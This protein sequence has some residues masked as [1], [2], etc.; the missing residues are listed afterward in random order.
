MAKKS[1]IISQV[2][3]AV[4]TALTLGYASSYSPVYACGESGADSEIVEDCEEAII[5][6]VEEDSKKEDDYAAAGGVV[7]SDASVSHSRFLAGNEINSADRVKGLK[8]AAGNIVRDSGSSEYALLAGNSI[9]VTGEIKNDLFAAGNS[10]EITDEASIGRDIYLAAETI[11]IKTNLFGNAFVGGQRV[12]LKD[13]TIDGDLNVSAEEIVILGKVAVSG[14]FT[15]NEDARFSGKENLEAGSF[16]TY[17]ANEWIR[18]AEYSEKIISTILSIVGRVIVTLVLVALTKKFSERLLSDFEL[19]NSWKDLALGLGLLLGIPLAVIF[20][21]VTIVGLPLGIIALVFYCVFAYLSK[22]VTGGV[23]GD[24]LAKNLFKKEKMNTL[25]KYALGTVVVVL[26]GMVPYV[27]GLIS[28]ISVCFGF[29]YLIH[30]LF[31][32][33]KR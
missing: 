22:S 6:E 30:S 21:V 23:V 29:G 24:L 14:K 26:V 5:E 9:S 2:C 13:I 25:A 11:L 28:A 12:V 1:T 20:A 27:G 33:E 7:D 18:S 4:L 16:S 15:Y 10:I 31:R 32:K 17:T 3:L 19:K 8:F